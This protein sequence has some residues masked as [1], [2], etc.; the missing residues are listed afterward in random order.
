MACALSHCLVVHQHFYSKA[1]IV[2]RACLS[3][4]TVFYPMI[5]ILLDNLLQDGL[6][7][8]KELL[9]LQVIQYE[10]QYK[11]LC[12]SNTTVQLNSPKKGFCSI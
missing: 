8:I 12:I 7:I 5:Q 4:K 3:Y 1:F 2:I 6:A 9:M 11:L 10:I